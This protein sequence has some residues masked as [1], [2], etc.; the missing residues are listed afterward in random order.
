[1]IHPVPKPEPTA[2]PARKRLQ[3][4]TR[5]SRKV[6]LKQ[7][8]RERLDKRT[9][10]YRKYMASPEW[11]AKHAACLARDQYTCQVCGYRKGPGMDAIGD[12]IEDRQLH[13]AHLTYIR[14]GHELLGDLVTK[15]A[16]C[17]LIKE[18]G[19]A[20]IKPRGLRG[21]RN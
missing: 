20:F 16:P 9:K 8:N 14:F 15:C 19:S 4:T 17:H 2:K 18:H 3:S 11:K 1:M 21:G 7:V 12:V 10:D 5:P 6:P 13:A